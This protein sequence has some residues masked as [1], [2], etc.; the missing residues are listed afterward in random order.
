VAKDGFIRRGTATMLIQR[1]TREGSKQH[2]L[3][4][5]TSGVIVMIQSNKLR[6]PSGNASAT[7]SRF[8]LR[9]TSTTPSFHDHSHDFCTVYQIVGIQSTSVH[10]ALELR[11]GPHRQPCEHVSCI[12]NAQLMRGEPMR[13]TPPFFGHCRYVL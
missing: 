13:M 9:A 2:S 5:S 1:R 3:R 11:Q 6:G 7:I 8:C 10:N 4:L 12:C